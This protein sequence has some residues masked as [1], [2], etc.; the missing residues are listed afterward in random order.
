MEGSGSGRGEG[1]GEE[2]GAG[3]ERERG[4]VSATDLRAAEAHRHLRRC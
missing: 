3:E 1:E 2:E 4:T